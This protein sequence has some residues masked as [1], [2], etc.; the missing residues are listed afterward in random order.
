MRRWNGWGDDTVIYPLHE[1]PR[2]FLEALVGPG[3]PP[4][5]ATLEE[6][7]AA[8][9]PSRLPMHPLISDD[10]VDRVRHARGQ[11]LPDWIA[12][13][14]GRLT[15]FPDGVAYPTTDAEVHSLIRY[16][17]QAGTRII[18]YGGGT[19]VVGHVNALPNDAPVFTVDLGRLNSLRRFDE[20]SGLATFGTGI[21]GP[22]LEAQLRARGFTLGHFPQSFELST[23][24]GWIVTRSSGQQSLGYGRI[25]KLFAGGRL[26]SPAG[27][28]ELPPFPASAAGPDLRDM[29]LGSEGRMGIL[30]EATVRVSPL[31]EEEA[32][33]AVFFRNFDRG[34]E[35]AR[36][37]MQA[38][39]PLSMVRLST[40]PETKTTLA[41][42]GHERLIGTLE[43]LL[44]LRGV[45]S[46]KCML[47]LGFTGRE[48][49]V[50][51]ARKEALGIA[52]QHGG[53][54]VG[55]TFGKE[56]HKSRFRTPYLRNTLWE[57]GYAI[58]TLE[59]ATD[60]ANIPTMVEAI[61]AALLQGLKEM[62]ER[63]H[64]FTHLS[65]LYPYGSSIYTTYLFR[66][67]SNPEETL[68]RWETLKRAASQA[69]VAHGGT[70]SHQHGVGTDHR[71]YL[72]EEKGS[73]GMAVLKDVCKRFDP[74]GIMNPG[75]LL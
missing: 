54:H 1:G 36:Q 45:G 27:T 22:D 59:T 12:L 25:E 40:A 7:A 34:R 6:V 4:Q 23:L 57:M 41:L 68:Y 39:L 63:V 14:G 21:T 47:L 17:R 10:P 11:S 53:V 48:A 32:F 37:I 5:D 55:Q 70:I 31:P 8:V 64:V 42:A 13:R 71:P 24:G 19:S 72:V 28:L 29:I 58:D 44:F 65:H 26:E 62:G 30:T 49:V 66:I 61:E 46:D 2:C 75:K 3:T 52:G 43:S 16:A 74:K 38:R 50:R 56:W 15:S 9:P 33:H 67:A 20:M 60:W 69:I 18:P 51:M 73:L 35:A